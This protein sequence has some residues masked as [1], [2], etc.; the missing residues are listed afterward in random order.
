[1]RD[2]TGQFPVEEWAEVEALGV[3]GAAALMREHAA[4]E[5]QDAMDKASRF[6]GVGKM[7]GSRTQPWQ[8]YID[9]IEDGKRRRIH[10]ATFAR[11]EDAACA[12]ERNC[13]TKF[14][15]AKA[16]TNFPVV[17]LLSRS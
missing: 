9:I 4:A 17:T 12:F 10:I 1:M 3:D 8:A 16:K 15:H 5:R 13:I 2:P 7:K 6:Q 14:G 11:E